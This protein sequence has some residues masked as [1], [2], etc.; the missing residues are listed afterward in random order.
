MHTY[1]CVE[2]YNQHGQLS[3]GDRAGTFD[4]ATYV[5][6]FRPALWNW[7]LGAAANAKVRIKSALTH[8]LTPYIYIHMYVYIYVYT[9]T[10][11]YI[12]IYIYIYIYT[13]TDG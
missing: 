6:M 10:Y 8:S 11:I 1:T 2:I 3:F 5:P 13:Y 9:Y 7:A 12:C 4:D